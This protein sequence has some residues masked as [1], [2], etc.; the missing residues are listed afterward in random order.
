MSN[1]LIRRSILGFLIGL[2]VILPGVSGASL[3]II[4]G[5]YDDLIISISNIFKDFKRS[6]IYLLPIFIFIILGVSIGLILLRGLINLLPF[7][8][9]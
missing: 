4:L 6:C 2:A 8:I 9:S 3:A 1:N 5:I 7:S